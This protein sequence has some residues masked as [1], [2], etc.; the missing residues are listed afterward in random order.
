M[1]IL[2]LMFGLLL[3]GL[4]SA[5]FIDS[6]NKDSKN[7]KY[8]IAGIFLIIGIIFALTLIFDTGLTNDSCWR[9][10]IKNFKKFNFIK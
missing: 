2:S 6:T 5:E 8:V 10:F 3:I 9:L 7:K 1:K 4:G